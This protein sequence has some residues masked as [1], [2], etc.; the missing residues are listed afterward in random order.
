MTT[1]W[2]ADTCSL[3]HCSVKCRCFVYRMSFSVFVFGQPFMKRFTPALCYQTVVLFCS[4]LSCLSVCNVR[5]LWTNGWMDQNETWH[6]GRPPPGNIVSD[7]DPAPPRNTPPIFRSCLLWPNG[8]MDLDAT[9]YRG[10]PRPRPH[11]VRL[12][13]SPPLPLPQKIFGPCLLWP[14]GW[15]DQDATW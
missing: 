6:G 14:K 1:T 10:R 11:S 13:L 3:V 8:W 9:W 12:R 4:V 5:V 2:V 7:G 15:M